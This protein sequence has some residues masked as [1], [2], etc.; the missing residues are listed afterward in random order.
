[1]IPVHIGKQNQRLLGYAIIDIH[2]VR[3]QPE[4]VLIV[5]EPDG[6][7]ASTTLLAVDE[8]LDYL[9][10]GRW[11]QQFDRKTLRPD[12]ALGEE[13]VA[14]TGGTLSISGV[15]DRARA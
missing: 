14:I 13:F 10:P 4:A 5:L 2:I 1:M 8:S 15:T 12:L 6:G 11:L 3:T 9:P 7:V